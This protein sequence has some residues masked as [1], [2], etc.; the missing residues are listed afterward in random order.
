MEAEALKEKLIQY[1]E[2]KELRYIDRG[3]KISHACISPDHIETNP[4]AFTMLN[5]ESFTYCS[6]CGF[7]LNT[8]KLHQFLD[9]G[10]DPDSLFISKINSMLKSLDKSNVKDNEKSVPMY[11]PIHEGNFEKEYRGIS[12]ET[13]RKVGAYYTIVGT[14]YEK[15]IIFPIYNIDNEL[16][17]FE[18]ISTN[19]KIVPKVLRPKAIKTV[20]L[21]GFENFIDSDTVFITEGLFSALSFIESGYNGVFNFGVGSIKPK[22]KKLL[23]KGV[24]NVIIA[25]DNDATGDKFYQECYQALRKNFRVLRFFYPYEFKDNNKFDPNDLLKGYGKEAMIKYVD[26]FLEKNLIF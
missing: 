21:L 26:R 19:K 22:I 20:D 12:V 9:V 14:Y 23:L 2:S 4:S 1:L 8:E 24:R 10:F 15:R 5:D 16:V 13:F 25:S 17:G 6:S 18:A 3:D 11:L 7:H